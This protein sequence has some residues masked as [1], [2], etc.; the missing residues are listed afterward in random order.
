VEL[1][2]QGVNVI[3]VS[4]QSIVVES[5]ADEEIIRNF[6][7]DIIHFQVML[8]CVGFEQ[9]RGKFYFQRVFLFQFFNEK[10]GSM[11]GVDN[12]FNQD[13]TASFNIFIQCKQTFH[14]PRTLNSCV[15]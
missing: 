7:T 12:I 2:N 13:H 1:I 4:S 11:A 5:V 8:Q 6:E 9:Q 3:Q 10:H 15:R 14:L